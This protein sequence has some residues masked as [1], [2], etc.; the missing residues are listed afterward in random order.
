MGRGRGGAGEERRRNRWERF[1]PGYETTVKEV[2]GEEVNSSLSS[3]PSFCKD[4]TSL[5][6]QG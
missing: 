6:A 2:A 5:T 1:L 4:D 3:N